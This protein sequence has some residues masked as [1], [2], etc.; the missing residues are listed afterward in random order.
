M[1]RQYKTTVKEFVT[2]PASVDKWNIDLYGRII[3]RNHRTVFPTSDGKIIFNTYAGSF[4]IPVGVLVQLTFKPVRYDFLFHL[5]QDVLYVDGNNLNLHPSNLI[6]K[7]V[8]DDVNCGEFKHIPGFSKYLI[9]SKGELFNQTEQRLQSTYKDANGYVMCGATHDAGRRVII[10]IHRLLALAF[11]EYTEKV[12]ILDVNHK[13]GLK[14]DNRLENLEWSTRSDNNKHACATGLKSD[15]NP[16]IVKN[17]YT[18]EITSYFSQA[19]CARALGIGNTTVDLRVKSRGLKLFPSGLLFKRKSDGDD[20]LE[21][22]EYGNSNGIKKSIVLENQNTNE[23]KKFPSI[24]SAAKFLGILSSTLSWRL[25]H[26]HNFYD[27][28]FISKSDHIAI[29]D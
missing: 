13:N 29:C 3:D 19:E 17:F 1:L 2:L 15:N 25:K 12:N 22:L 27:G 11:L 10:G 26:N 5:Q 14:D 16:V 23:V 20:W 21:K 4:L 8:N 7:F 6:W 9:N 18:G 24:A 28:W